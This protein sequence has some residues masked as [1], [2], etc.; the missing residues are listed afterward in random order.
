MTSWLALE[1]FPYLDNTYVNFRMQSMTFLYK[2][3]WALFVLFLRMSEKTI[4]IFLQFS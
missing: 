4:F 2:R 1:V 3:K